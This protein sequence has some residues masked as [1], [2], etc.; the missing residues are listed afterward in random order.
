ME[1]ARHRFVADGYGATTIDA[2]AADAEVSAATVYSAFGSKRAL[3]AAVVD[4]TVAEEGNDV[5][6][7][8][9]DWVKALRE[10]PD[11]GGRIRALYAGLRVLYERTAAID[12]VVEEAAGVDPEVAVLSA[13]LGRRQRADTT[14]LLEVVV[15]DRVLFSG[16]TP[17]EACDAVWAILGTSVYRRLVEECG[18]S[19]AQWER[20]AVGLAEQLLK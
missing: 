12:R 6:F 15:G 19:P 4:A 14:V 3:L 9:T 11:T 7:V 13:E 17:T 16:L 2:I 8:E 1:A 20:W 5:P 18:W 10:I